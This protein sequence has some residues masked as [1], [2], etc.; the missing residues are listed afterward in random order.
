MD[1]QRRNVI[2]ALIQEH[3][4]NLFQGQ[5]LLQRRRKARRQRV[6]WVRPWIA[7]RPEFGIYSRLMVELRNEDPRAFQHFMRMPQPCLMKLWQGSPQDWSSQQSISDQTWFSR[8][9]RN[10][11]VMFAMRHQRVLHTFVKVPVRFLTTPNTFVYFLPSSAVTSV[12]LF[13]MFPL[14]YT[15]HPPYI[16]AVSVILTHYFADFGN[17]N[18]GWL[19]KT[20]LSVLNSFAILPLLTRTGPWAAQNPGNGKIAMCGWM[21]ILP[22]WFQHTSRVWRMSCEYPQI[23]SATHL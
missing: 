2:I 5:Q 8:Q 10:A 13:V 17:I 21:R 3:N 12:I 4:N 7:R 22:E 9:E 19:R 11:F 18:C 6:I 20:P 15:I 23:L 1:R 16:I 14:L